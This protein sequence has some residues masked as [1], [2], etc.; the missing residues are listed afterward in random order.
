[1]GSEEM[2][3]YEI[4]T[5][6]KDHEKRLTTVEAQIQMLHLDLGELTGLIR[7][8]KWWLVGVGSFYIIDQVG[9]VGF[10]SKAFSF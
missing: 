2:K 1:M 3:H 7:N 5:E 4:D 10:I 6:L 9:I 8:I